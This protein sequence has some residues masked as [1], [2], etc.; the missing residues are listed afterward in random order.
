MWC[1]VE[2]FSRNEGRNQ[3]SFYIA[4]LNPAL[5]PAG[6]HLW[7]RALKL[8]PTLALH[9]SARA[10]ESWLSCSLRRR[11][12]EQLTPGAVLSPAAGSADMGCALSD[13]QRL[14][15]WLPRVWRHLNECL[16][17][18][19]PEEPLAR[20]GPQYLLPAALPE[21]TE[22]ARSWL[23]DL[24]N[25]LLQPLYV[26]LARHS[27]QQQ[28]QQQQQ[29]Q[30]SQTR[31][32]LNDPAIFLRATCVWTGATRDRFCSALLALPADSNFVLT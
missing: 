16:E 17:R 22:A 9:A 13:W 14:V 11:L 8:L 23:Q 6:E 12:I 15:N 26:Q 18:A 19:L 20:I 10:A 27:A 5:L 25:Y 1:A 2:S 24:Y 30:P 29:Q 7:L 4:A 3:S 28:Q 21:D 31:G 32:D